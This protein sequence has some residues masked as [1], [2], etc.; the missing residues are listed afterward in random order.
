MAAVRG[1]AAEIQAG[2]F[3]PHG[4]HPALNRAGCPRQ[5]TVNRIVDQQVTSNTI[6][7]IGKVNQTLDNDMENLQNIT[8]LIGFDPRTERFLNGEIQGDKPAVGTEDTGNSGLRTSSVKQDNA[9]NYEIK[10]YLQGFTT[11]YP[12]IASILLVNR[13]GEYISN[14]MYA[15]SPASLTEEEWYREAVLNEGIL[16]CLATRQSVMSPPMFIT[17]TRNWYRSFARLWIRI[18]GK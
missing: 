10:R 15:R 5:L 12:E 11:L 18:R 17:A 9:E 3:V 6:Q 7:L 2:H 13:E 8:Y 4:W 1:F 14:E 16:P